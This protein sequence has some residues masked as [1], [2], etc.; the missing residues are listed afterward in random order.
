MSCMRICCD[1]SIKLH[2][3]ES[4]LHG[5]NIFWFHCSYLRCNSRAE[6]LP[7]YWI[8]VDSCPVQLLRPESP[9]IKRQIIYR[10]LTGCTFVSFSA[11]TIIEQIVEN[12]YSVSRDAMHPFLICKSDYDMKSFADVYLQA[13]NSLYSQNKVSAIK[14]AEISVWW[15][16]STILL[17]IGI[18]LLLSRATFFK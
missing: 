10:L 7:K 16:K 5:F 15:L 3:S 11:S 8:C 6:Y 14:L 17:K 18:K 2:N 1:H 9:K 12:D 4:M 13:I